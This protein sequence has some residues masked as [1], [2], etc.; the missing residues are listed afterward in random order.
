MQ[1]SVVLF[2]VH[3]GVSICS[4]WQHL[5]GDELKKRL[6]ITDYTLVA[7]VFPKEE[8]SV[9]LEPEWQ[10][11]VSADRG[12]LVSIECSGDAQSCHELGALETSE[13]CLF[14]GQNLLSRYQGPR[15]ASAKVDGETV[16]LSSFEVEEELDAWVTEASRPVIAELTRL[17]RQRLLNRGKPMIYIFSPSEAERADM[18][19][20][21]AKL[22]RSYYDSLTV[23]TADPFDF[24]DLVNRFGLG[25]C[26]N[27]HG[28]ALSPSYPAG[29]VHQLST[30]RIYRYPIGK[31][32]TSDALTRWGLS[33][34]QGHVQPWTPVSEGSNIGEG[35]NGGRGAS[36]A[37]PLVGTKVATRRVSKASNIP[38]LKIRVAGRDEL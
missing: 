36:S 11:A 33:I 19:N 17:N 21:L 20:R 12:N 8:K 26:S 1:Y 2:W 30:D 28:N 18:R 35:K 6:V 22:A 27:G 14:S 9:W 16:T 4:A 3:W 37:N 24:P 7:F 23:V 10:L 5:S 13:I 15:R 34:V 32:L 25:K 31:A 29:V 38:G